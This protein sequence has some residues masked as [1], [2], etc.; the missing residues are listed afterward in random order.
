[1]KVKTKIK[2]DKISV[3]I[4][5]DN[6]SFCVIM[7]EA[8]NRSGTL[9][10]TG[11]Y[12]TVKQALHAFDEI[13]ERPNVILL[14]IKMPN[15]SGVEGIVYIKRYCPE[16]SIVMLTSFDNES[17]IKRSLQRG[18][19]G[20]L[21]KTSNHIDI[22]RSIERLAEGGKIIDPTIAERIIES[23][24]PKKPSKDYHLTSRE[25]EVIRLLI[26][27]ITIAQVAENLKISYYTAE[28]H[29]RNAFDKL[30]V[31][32]AHHLVAKA[33]KEGII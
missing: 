31:H 18:A 27:G 32:S 9:I 20:Y 2:K 10:C 5:D 28:T 11:Y 13:E 25:K 24:I 1:M 15:M 33:I 3:V 26:S 21:S 7:S 23:I 17:D 29:R 30:E 22:I 14:D 6:V 8:I 12:H 19:K 4:I 16:T